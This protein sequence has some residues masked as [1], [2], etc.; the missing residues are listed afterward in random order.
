[1]DTVGLRRVLIE[2]VRIGLGH[3]RGE[4]AVKCRPV[5]RRLGVERQVRAGVVADRVGVVPPGEQLAVTAPAVIFDPATL[6]GVVRIRVVAALVVAE[7]VGVVTHAGAVEVGEP[8]LLAVGT[9]QPA[10][11]VVKGPVLH[12]HH[13]HHHH[14]VVDARGTRIRKHRNGGGAPLRTERCRAGHTRR[15]RPGTAAA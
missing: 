2:P 12:H 11:V 10:Q 9:R 4:I 15:A 1:M 14:D 3:R 13:H 7:V 8:G 5:R 6:V